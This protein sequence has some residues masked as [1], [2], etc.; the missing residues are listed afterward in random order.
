MRRTAKKNG[1]QWAR[2]AGRSV[3]ARGSARSPDELRASSDSV[4]RA[5][6]TLEQVVP[7]AAPLPNG[8]ARTSWEGWASASGTHGGWERVRRA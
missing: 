2:G 4:R 1:R 6:V 3:V 5:S 8:I 7:N